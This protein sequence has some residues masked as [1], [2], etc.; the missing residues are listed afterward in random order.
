MEFSFAFRG[1]Q[2]LDD[3]LFNPVKP[4]VMLT[5]RFLAFSNLAGRMPIETTRSRCAG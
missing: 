4:V 1:P 2:A 3:R 5:S